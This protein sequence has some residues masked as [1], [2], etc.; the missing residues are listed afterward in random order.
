MKRVM[1]VA[2]VGALLLVAA[3]CS[4]VSEAITVEDAWGRA[5]PKAAANGAFYMT[6]TGGAS[7]DVLVSAEAGACSVVELHET[8][9]NDGAMKMQH[10]PD[11][12]ELAAGETVSLEPG[13]KH[14][15]CIDKKAEFVAGDSIS[16]TLSFEA[17]DDM[18]VEFEIRDQ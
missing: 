3:A 13:G 8:V 11:G 14:I 15:M 16:A 17:S 4:G 2:I 7:D 5:S 6:L 10:L 1:L 18:M 12:I 9:T